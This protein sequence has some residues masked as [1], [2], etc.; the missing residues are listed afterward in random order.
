MHLVSH[1]NRMMNEAWILIICIKDD[2]GTI[3]YF[4]DRT[5]ESRWDKPSHVEGATTQLASLA[6]S[7]PAASSSSAAPNEDA[8]IELEQEGLRKLNP[9][10]LSQ[11]VSETL[12]VKACILKQI[13]S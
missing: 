10:E 12:V 5:G 6:L 13:M 11:L 8:H 4:N 7:P 9:A 3:Y 2:N 1:Y